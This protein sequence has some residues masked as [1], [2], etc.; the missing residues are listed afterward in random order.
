M[1]EKTDEDEDETELS[2]EEAKIFRGSAA[3]LNYLGQDRPDLQFAT[4][5]ICQKMS[6]P[7]L[8]GLKMIKRAARYLVGASRVVWKFEDV[9]DEAG[10]VTIDVY[11]D[12]DWAG[13]VDRRSTSGGVAALGGVAIKHWSRTQ[14][15]RALSSTEAEYYALVTGAAEGLGIRS[16]A[17]DL[18]WLMAVR[19]WTDSSGAKGAAARRGLG[20][21]RHVELKYLWVQQAAK[22]GRIE[23][24]KVHGEENPA[25]HLTKP[26]NKDEMTKHLAKI[27]GTLI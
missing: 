12:S 8:G 21:L 18:G 9:E 17:E 13:S 27:G 19:I 24:K 22:E 11:V 20:K 2:R 25:D 23:I 16:L 3:R 14:K 1:K 7:T 26:K 10:G 4:K 5:Q 15:S 6:R